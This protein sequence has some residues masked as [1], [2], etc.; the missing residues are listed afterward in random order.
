MDHTYSG[1]IHTITLNGIEVGEL[2]I[3][4]A[5]VAG[6]VRHKNQNYFYL[7]KLINNDKTKVRHLFEAQLND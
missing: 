7:K 2:G 3:N 5:V 1:Q 6:Y 4:A